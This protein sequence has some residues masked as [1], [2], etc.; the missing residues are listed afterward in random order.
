MAETMKRIID[1]N[2][3]GSGQ[4]VARC[5]LRAHRGNLSARLVKSHDC[6]AKKCPF[7]EKMDVKFWRAYEAKKQEKKK[8]TLLKK[9]A[10]AEKRN[11]EA[12]VREILEDNGHIHVTVIREESSNLL[13]ISYIYDERVDLTPETEILRDKLGKEIKLQARIGSHSAIEQLIRNPRRRARNAADVRKAPK[14]SPYRL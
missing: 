13:V 8:R 6:I 2:Y 11:R 5:H 10:I 14:V 3:V 7:L 4:I 1:G 12:M 9:L